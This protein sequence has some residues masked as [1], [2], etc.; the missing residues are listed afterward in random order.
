MRRNHGQA[1]IELLAAVALL[2][3]VAGGA[4]QLAAI[5]NAATLAQNAARVAARAHAVGD[6]PLLAARSAL[7]TS[8][9]GGLEVRTSDG[10]VR[11]R[12]VARVFWGAAKIDL[13]GRAALGRQAP[14]AFARRAP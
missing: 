6:D 2:L 10:T 13:F 11:T 12:V 5:G 8:L 9:R 4:W 14:A 1:S 7:P 3:L